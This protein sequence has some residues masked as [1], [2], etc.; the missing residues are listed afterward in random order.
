MTTFYEVGYKAAD[1]WTFNPKMACSFLTFGVLLC[2]GYNG[3][4]LLN[5]PILT[6]STVELELKN[7]D[8]MGPIVPYDKAKW[9]NLKKLWINRV[10]YT[11]L[12]GICRRSFT[13][14]PR[15][16][17]TSMHPPQVTITR[18]MSDV[19]IVLLVFG[20]LIFTSI[21]Y[22]IAVCMEWRRRCCTWLCNKYRRC[23]GMPIPE[24]EEEDEPNN[25]SILVNMGRRLRERFSF[26]EP[27]TS[28]PNPLPGANSGGGKSKAPSGSGGG[29]SSGGG[30]YPGP[31]R[32]SGAN[33][34]PDDMERNIM[35][36]H[37]MSTYG[38][39]ADMSSCIQF[40][41]HTAKSD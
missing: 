22:V 14:P 33:A 40:K 16:T 28:T 35:N 15:T 4:Y 10:G 2:L 26:Q 38:H 30:V 23:R 36:D 13:A 17:P 18:R 39:N 1:R 3:L 37:Y 25:Q 8:A 19:G 9:T 24:E 11:C 7:V 29:S 27:R 32:S 6:K 20:V 31:S 5:D 34:Y 41:K 12:G 21:C